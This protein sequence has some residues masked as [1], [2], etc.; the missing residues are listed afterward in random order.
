MNINFKILLLINIIST[1]QSCEKGQ[2]FVI[3][4]KNEGVCEPCPAN[5]LLCYQ[6][7]KNKKI[8]GFCNNGFYMT[9]D[10]RCLPCKENCSKCQGPTVEQCNY[11][12]NGFFYNSISKTIDKCKIEGCAKCPNKN[13]CSNCLK[14]F[15]IAKRESKDDKVTGVECKACNIE[16]CSFCTEAEDQI[17]K[18]KFLKCTHCDSKFGLVNGKCEKC[19][20]K[21][22]FCKENTSTCSLCAKGYTMN[23]KN[24]T[25][26]K[27]KI[28]HCSDMKD[29][30]DCKF[31]DMHYFMESS[32]ICKTC[33]SK[34]ANCKKCKFIEDKFSCYGCKI[35]FYKDA[36]ENCQKCGDNC[37]HCDEKLCYV[38]EDKYFFNNKTKKCQK[39]EIDKCNDCSDVDVC[40]DCRR[41]FYFNSE[42]KKCEKCLDNCLKCTNDG[43]N[44]FSCPL[45]FFTLQE[46]FINEQNQSS[47]TSLLPNLL[48]VLFGDLIKKAAFKVMEIK[49]I[50]K[51]VEKCPLEIK[52]KKVVADLSKRRC[53]VI[54]QGNEN[55]VGSIGMPVFNKET[56]VL[57][58][59][60]AL[61]ARYDEEI[62]NVKTSLIKDDGNLIETSNKS[63]ECFNKGKLVKKVRGIGSFYIC[64]CNE[65]FIGDNCQITQHLFNEIQENI[66][67]ALDVLQTKFINHDKHSQKIL[68]KCLLLTTKFKLGKEIIQK[69]TF[70]LKTTLEHNRELDNRKELYLLYDALILNLYDILE[71]QKKEEYFYRIGDTELLKKRKEIFGNIQDI[72]LM[73]EHSLED[74]FYAESFLE[75]GNENY[76]NFDTFGYT[77]AE[78]RF[79]DHMKNYEIRNP[80]IDT[81]FNVNDFNQIWFDFNSNV[82][83]IKSPYNIQILN[84]AAAL[85]EDQ[86][87]DFSDILITNLIYLKNLD[88]AFPNK[89]VKNDQVGI[90]KILLTFA[91]LFVPAF[92]EIESKIYC[93]AYAF[94][95]EKTILYGSLSHVNDDNQ[96]VTCEFNADFE[97]KKYYFGVAMNK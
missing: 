29:E 87:T 27:N 92:D 93:K 85:F 84:F 97:F 57:N 7:L 36:N 11:P 73:I 65:G 37:N 49:I 56:D 2:V 88:V 76:L 79:K 75:K 8:C 51:C 59:L 17:K 66:K 1:I 55:K 26:E 83:I 22:V 44:C 60:V 28:E 24:N 80:N 82:N 91:M 89:T 50:N 90:K 6:G 67:Q 32:K 38:C 41:G 70:L 35:G 42:T 15:Y 69:I 63:Q 23:E 21:C 20:D 62:M 40:K 78:Y 58:N 48:S 52:G 94:D 77:M 47:K 64:K 34:V 95:K 96:S 74:L 31:C 86:I 12:E 53:T 16:N 4:K 18:L 68:F 25:C 3:N 30:E 54:I 14:G 39:C 43:K 19:P 5:C 33:A 72:I 61:K 46:E 45:N 81:S 71:D 9:S 10:K 13:E